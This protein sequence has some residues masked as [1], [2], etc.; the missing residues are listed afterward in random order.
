MIN[1]AHASKLH[2]G[3]RNLERYREKESLP[4]EWRGKGAEKLMK[5]S[6]WF[7]EGFGKNL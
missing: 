3:R 4:T 2:D 7:R 5:M 1:H 6:R